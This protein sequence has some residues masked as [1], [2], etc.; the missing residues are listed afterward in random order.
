MEVPTRECCTSTSTRR[1][2]TR[3]LSRIKATPILVEIRRTK[4]KE[5]H[6][7]SV[8]KADCMRRSTASFLWAPRTGTASTIAIRF[9]RVL[10]VSSALL[11]MS[12]MRPTQFTATWPG[13]RTHTFVPTERGRLRCSR[14]SL[15][16]IASRAR[17][18]GSPNLGKHPDPKAARSELASALRWTGRGE[19]LARLAGAGEQPAFSPRRLRLFNT[20]T[21]ATIHEID[22][23]TMILKVKLAKADTICSIHQ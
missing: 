17:R 9:G 10:F 21:S 7:L 18:S 6:R 23:V 11:P 1:A 5:K 8:A 2:H 13:H 12:V 20:A 4:T 16:H 15:L 19:P 14:S 3:S 22:F